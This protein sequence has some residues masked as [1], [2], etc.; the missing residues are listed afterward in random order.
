MSILGSLW[1]GYQAAQ[2][3]RG[4]VEAGQAVLASG[5]S[6]RAC[7]E[8]F[9]AATGSKL[10]DAA[11]AE[12]VA[13]SSKALVML[14]AGVSTAVAVAGWLD[15]HRGQV[16]AGADTVARVVQQLPALAQR[17]VSIAESAAALAQQVPPLV[18]RA[19]GWAAVGGRWL[20]VIAIRIEVLQR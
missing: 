12:L 14:G 13:A 19:T 16:Q 18:D 8:A 17:A 2:E 6:V 7:L 20:T 4:A 3:A 1:A 15:E 11:L 9:A 10:D 5:G